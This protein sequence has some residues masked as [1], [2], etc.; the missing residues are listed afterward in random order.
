MYYGKIFIVSMI[1]IAIVLFMTG[2]WTLSVHPLY[3][4]KDL[5]FDPA[6]IG[7]WGEKETGDGPGD[8]WTF[9]KS[10]EKSY[11]LLIREEDG[12]EGFFEAHLVKIDKF[13]FLDLYPEEPEGVNDFYMSHVIPA[14][15]FMR[16]SLEGHVLRFA[17][18]DSQW[19]EE[20]IQQKKVLIKHEIRDDVI[21]LTA[22][23][24]Q[25]QEFVMTYVETAF[26]FKEDVLYRK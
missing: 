5:V 21:V 17:I 12:E 20:S 6:L 11:R 1:A 2:C 13:L 8:I 3:F 10:D 23:T 24:A 4:E 9:M 25:L 19:L 7:V 15:S 16:V 26:P 18:L 14:H 22:S